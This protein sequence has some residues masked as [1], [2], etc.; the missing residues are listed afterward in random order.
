MSDKSGRVLNWIIRTSTALLHG[1]KTLPAAGSAQPPPH[2]GCDQPAQ[3]CRSPLTIRAMSMVEAERRQRSTL[4]TRS[5]RFAPTHPSS[6]RLCF[7]ASGRHSTLILSTPTRHL[8][9]AYVIEV[10]TGSGRLRRPTSVGEQYGQS[11]KFIDGVV[12]II[13]LLGLLR[14]L[15]WKG[16]GKGT[17]VSGSDEWGMAACAA[18]VGVGL[19]R[20]GA[21]GGLARSTIESH[22]L[23]DSPGGLSRAKVDHVFKIDI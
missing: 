20:P 17:L 11:Q 10:N 5:S 13:F 15:P 8:H 23:S 16:G 3:P 19:D 21:A 7:P 14:S 9:R 4:A 22:N 18:S 1:N 2:V 6:N 12:H